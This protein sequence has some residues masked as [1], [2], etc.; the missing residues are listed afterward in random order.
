MIEKIERSK[1]KKKTEEEESVQI[2]PVKQMIKRIENIERE[3]IV[4]LKKPEK[5]NQETGKVGSNRK[6]VK[7]RRRMEVKEDLVKVDRKWLEQS[8]EKADRKKEKTSTSVRDYF[9]PRRGPNSLVKI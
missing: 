6:V 4:E 8:D 3:E 7:G 2:G 1:D 5:N 9:C